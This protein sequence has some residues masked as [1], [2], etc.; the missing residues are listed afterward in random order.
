MG[1]V[2]YRKC[3]QYVC[4]IWDP[5]IN[6]FLDWEVACIKYSLAK[7]YVDLWVKLEQCEPFRESW[8]R[9]GAQPNLVE[10][11]WFVQRSRGCVVQT[12]S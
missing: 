4:D 9:H 1:F 6:D 12:D 5:G 7:I 2:L 11:G 8:S 3:L 10:M